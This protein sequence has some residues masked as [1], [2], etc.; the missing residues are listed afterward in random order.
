[1]TTD[2]NQ[3]TKNGIMEDV[4]NKNNVSLQ[5]ANLSLNDE[6]RLDIEACSF[7]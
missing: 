4:D 2:V 7:L 3:V 1:M 6:G 5:F